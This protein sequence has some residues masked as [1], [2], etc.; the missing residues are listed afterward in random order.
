MLH[1]DWDGSVVDGAKVRCDQYNPNKKKRKSIV[2]FEE[3]KSL[4]RKVE[5]FFRTHPADLVC[6]EVP[7]GGKGLYAIDK[8]FMASG[9]S[10]ALLAEHKDTE[11]IPLTPSEVKKGACGENGGNPEFGRF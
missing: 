1:P 9:M 8:L 6:L 5:K 4:A 3:T 7:S 10:C 11:V 2:Y